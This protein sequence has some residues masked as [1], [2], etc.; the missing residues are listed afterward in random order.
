MTLDQVFEFIKQYGPL[1]PFIV[2]WWLERGE[3]IDAQNELKQI[4]KESVVAMT[5]ADATIGQL[6]TVF[7]P[8]HS[9]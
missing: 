7:K 4:A 9:P 3:R 6:I 1:A 2:L 5:K 8:G